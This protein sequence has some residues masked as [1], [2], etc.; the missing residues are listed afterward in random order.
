MA[1]GLVEVSDVNNK[2]NVVISHGYSAKVIGN[3]V[4]K[5]ET[6][7][8]N[9]NSWKTGAF[10]F[11]DTDIAQVVKDLNTYYKKQIILEEGASIDCRLTANFNKAKLQEILDIM[12]LTCDFTVISNAKYYTIK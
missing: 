4:E 10:T 2:N 8:P 7:K 1:T 11:K 9:Y 6:K 5:F 12:E 3:N